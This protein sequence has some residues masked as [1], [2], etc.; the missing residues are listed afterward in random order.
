MAKKKQETKQKETLQNMTLDEAEKLIFEQIKQGKNPR[1]IS[2]LEIP[3]DGIV[4]KF[5][6]NQI[7]KIKEKFSPKIIEKLRDPDKAVAFKLFKK[8]YP[9]IEVVIKTK[10]P[11]E[12]VQKA[13]EEFLEFEGKQ[14]FFK[15]EIQDLYEFV[16]K[17]W[18]PCDSLLD[19]KNF[20]K[21]LI[22]LRNKY[23]ELLFDCEKCGYPIY[24]EGELLDDARNYLAQHYVHPECV[25]K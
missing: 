14:V 4:K 15:N 6:I 8:G 7:H 16:K 25:K 2:Q 9:S 13:Y 17:N 24:P 10:L 19:V 18:W 1:E 22:P 11:S 23:L 21:Q 20:L 5:N 12:F 3:I